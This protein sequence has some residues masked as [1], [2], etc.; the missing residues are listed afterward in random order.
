MEKKP[1]RMIEGTPRI[2]IDKVIPYAN[3]ARI[4]EHVV[5][6]IA[7]SISRFGFN[8][9]I[10]LDENNVIVCGHT[11]VKAAKR[12]GMKEVPC[13]YVEGLTQKEIDAYRL[14]DNKLAE[15]AL[16]DYEK[17]NAELAK[18]GN[19]ISMTDFGFREELNNKP[20]TE[21]FEE[22]EEE[23]QEPINDDV[24]STENYRKEIQCPN[25]GHK[26]IP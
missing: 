17:L 20:L 15:Q 14:A 6:A 25:C 24:G 12:L 23:E 1:I 22:R 16:W 5:P 7:R 9:P 11:R 21:L 10:V 19:E 4:N 13:V 3:N 26:F 18:I 2:A 8:E